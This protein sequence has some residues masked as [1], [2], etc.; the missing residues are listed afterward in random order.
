[1]FILD[2]TCALVTTA[3]VIEKTKCS[4]F[5]MKGMRG[6]ELICESKKTGGTPPPGVSI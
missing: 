1:M 3:L 4:E 6:L 2:I 5:L